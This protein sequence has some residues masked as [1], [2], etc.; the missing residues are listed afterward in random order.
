M[1]KTLS[2]RSDCNQCKEKLI[3]NNKDNSHFHDKYLRLVSRGGLAVPSLAIT[4]FILQTFSILHYIS[5][6][7]H[8][9]TKTKEKL[10]KTFYQNV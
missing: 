9:V 8:D 4:D 7:V 6:T 2:L 1:A 3:F 10:S 5:P